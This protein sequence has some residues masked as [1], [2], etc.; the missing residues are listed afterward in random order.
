MAKGS[1]GDVEGAGVAGSV[2]EGGSDTR[3]ETG[4]L[5]HKSPTPI[6]VRRL[7][8]EGV[9]LACWG[10]PPRK[11]ILVIFPPALLRRTSP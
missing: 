9:S 7:F 5:K 4:L 6:G 10:C 1:A 3:S 2:D 8:E 11:Q